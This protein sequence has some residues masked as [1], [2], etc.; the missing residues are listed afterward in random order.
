MYQHKFSKWKAFRKGIMPAVGAYIAA[1]M[2]GVD[3]SAILADPQKQ[4]PV[5]GATLAAGLIPALVNT[6]KHR[7]TAGNPF[8]MLPILL[9]AGLVATLA[10]CITTTAPDGTVTQSVDSQGVLDTIDGAVATWDRLEARRQAIEV[11]REAAR[12]AKDAEALARL[13][14]ELQRLEPALSAAWTRLQGETPLLLRIR[15]ADH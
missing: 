11:Q 15:G 9:A 8:P 1:S 12:A 5:I 3:L 13:D 6:W 14:A 4:L 10:G 7:G 2:A